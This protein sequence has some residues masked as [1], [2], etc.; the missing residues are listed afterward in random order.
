MIVTAWRYLLADSI[1][2]QSLGSL[3]CLRSRKSEATRTQHGKTREIV[4]LERNSPAGEDPREAEDRSQTHDLL[5]R[6]ELVTRNDDLITR[7]QIGRIG[8]L[9]LVDLRNVDGDRG[10]QAAILPPQNINPALA[11]RWQHA[12]RFSQR[13][14]NGQAM[15]HQ[16]NSRLSHVANDAVTIR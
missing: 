9:A 2:I 6:L 5:Q 13:F 3:C 14:G 4:R 10:E 8:L 11:A 12:A 15:A 16:T 1:R 7:Y